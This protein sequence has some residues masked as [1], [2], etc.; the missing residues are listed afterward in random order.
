MLSKPKTNSMKRTFGYAAAKVW[1]ERNKN[2][3]I[4][5]YL[6]WVGF[7]CEYFTV[8]IWGGWMGVSYTVCNYTQPNEKQRKR[9]KYFIVDYLPSIKM[10]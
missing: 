2:S 6:I 8:I 4:I 9:C 7:E 5:F 3:W 10:F 1:N